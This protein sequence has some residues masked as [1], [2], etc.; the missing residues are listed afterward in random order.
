ML[1]VVKARSFLRNLF[2]S[3]RADSDLNEELHSHL[4]MLAEEKVRDGMALNEAQR[5]ARIELGGVE[6]LKEHVRDQPGRNFGS[7]WPLATR[8]PVTGAT[9]C[10]QLSAG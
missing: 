1:L 8:S 7:P 9:A 5:A 10:Y 2:L 6:Q 4:E 3:R